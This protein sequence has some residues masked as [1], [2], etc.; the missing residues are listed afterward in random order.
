MKT[1]KTKKLLALL[2]KRE[3][4]ITEEQKKKVYDELEKIKNEKF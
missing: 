1:E 4:T 2:K 3:N